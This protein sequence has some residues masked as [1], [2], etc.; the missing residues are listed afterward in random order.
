MD[1]AVYTRPFVI[2]IQHDEDGW[3]IAIVPELPGC[4][5]QARTKRELFKRIWEAIDLA[6]QDTSDQ[7]IKRGFSRAGK[8]R[9]QSFHD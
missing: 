8:W 2:Q 1:T 3:L 7:V 5:T 9:C 4:Y 6:L